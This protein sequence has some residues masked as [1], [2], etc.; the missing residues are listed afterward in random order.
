M[1]ITKLN[2]ANMA[3]ALSKMLT[4]MGQ[5]TGDRPKAKVTEYVQN[6]IIWLEFPPSALCSEH[7]FIERTLKN[8]YIKK[9]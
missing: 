5:Y 4:A 3:P 2:Y 7:F 9:C 1:M 8:C 6:N